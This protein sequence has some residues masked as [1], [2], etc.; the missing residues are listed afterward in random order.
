MSNEALDQGIATLQDDARGPPDHPPASRPHAPVTTSAPRAPIG[1]GARADGSRRAGRRRAWR[2]PGGASTAALRFGVPAL[3]ALALVAAG[4]GL[5]V[6]DRGSGQAAREA[7]R[8]ARAIGLGIIQPRLTDA[9][10]AGEPHAVAGL[11]AFVRRRVLPLDAAID[12]LALV[13]ADERIV[14]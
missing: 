11:D 12:H 2:V 7:G 6:R 10:L 9:V 13:N 1:T 5:A 14:Y 8:M 4:G 3:I